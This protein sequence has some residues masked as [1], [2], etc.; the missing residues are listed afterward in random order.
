MV[1]MTML[2]GLVTAKR[3]SFLALMT[4]LQDNYRQ[5][6]DSVEFALIGLEKHS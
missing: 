1:K 4:V 6:E 3:L 2:L 5:L